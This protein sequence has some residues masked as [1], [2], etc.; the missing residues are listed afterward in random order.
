MDHFRGNEV[1]DGHGQIGGGHMGGGGHEGG[2]GR[3]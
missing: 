3:R 2:G 1:H